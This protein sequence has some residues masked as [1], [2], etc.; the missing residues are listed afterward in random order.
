MQEENVESAPFLL[1]KDS[2]GVS[3]YWIHLNI[4]QKTLYAFIFFFKFWHVTIRTSIAK[5]F[6]FRLG[7]QDLDQKLIVIPCLERAFVP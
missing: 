4:S 7:K 5:A 3:I 2:I 1:F 6:F